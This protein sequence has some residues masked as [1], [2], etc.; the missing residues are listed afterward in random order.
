MDFLYC[1][2]AELIY[3]TG[4]LIG[5]EPDASSIGSKRMAAVR[6]H[7]ASAARALARIVRAH[8]LALQLERRGRS[9]RPAL[10]FSPL[11]ADYDA[12]R[13]SGGAAKNAQATAT[14]SR[15]AIEAELAAATLEGTDEARAMGAAL[16]FNSS[17][18]RSTADAGDSGGAKGDTD[19]YAALTFVTISMALRHNIDPEQPKDNE[20]GSPSPPL[21]P[22]APS[23]PPSG[24]QPSPPL[25]YKYYGTRG[26]REAVKDIQQQLS[27]VS[28]VNI[29]KQVPCCFD[30]R[31]NGMLSCT[32]VGNDRYVAC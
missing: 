15:A 26:L 28:I 11:F 7:A 16:F 29:A 23:S 20:K 10:D 32:Q 24:K 4:I 21:D 14:L 3:R 1:F 13:R 9:D 22:T 17:L 8:A 2:Q 6:H 19:V 30:L 5:T 18:Q 27:N 25:S 31:A 12:S